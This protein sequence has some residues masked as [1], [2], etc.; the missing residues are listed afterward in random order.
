MSLRSRSIQT[1]LFGGRKVRLCLG[2]VGIVTVGT[3]RLVCETVNLVLV[4]LKVGLFQ[5]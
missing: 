3:L 1:Y 2:E 5:G 4:A